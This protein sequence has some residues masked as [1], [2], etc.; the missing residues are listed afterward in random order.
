MKVLQDR[1]VIVE[2]GHFR[3]VHSCVPLKHGDRVEAVTVAVTVSHW[4]Q[5]QKKG[6]ERSAVELKERE[7]ER[8]RRAKGC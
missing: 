7:G 4:Y 3:S 6:G 2:D 1:L 5:V 8:E